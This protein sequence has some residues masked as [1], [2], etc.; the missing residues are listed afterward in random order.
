MMSVLR[1]SLNSMIKLERSRESPIINKSVTHGK[2]LV[3]IVNGSPLIARCVANLR[4]AIEARSSRA[5][6]LKFMDH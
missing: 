1:G 6:T 5:S 2:V 4:C 3:D